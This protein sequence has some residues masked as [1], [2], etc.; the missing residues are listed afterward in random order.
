MQAHHVS[1]VGL[2]AV[3]AVVGGLRTQEQREDR[4]IGGVGQHRREARL[5][6]QGLRLRPSALDRALPPAEGDRE[7]LLLQRRRRIENVEHLA[8]RRPRARGRGPCA[9]DERES[10]GPARLGDGGA[11][12][13]HRTV[14]GC[15]ARSSGARP[16]TG[17][18]PVVTAPGAEVVAI[19]IVVVFVEVVVVLGIDVLVEVLIARFVFRIGLGAIGLSERGLCVRLAGLVEDLPVPHGAATPS[20]NEPSVLFRRP[21]HGPE[22]LAGG[23]A[24]AVVRARALEGQAR[25]LPAHL[26][27]IGLAPLDDG[28]DVRLGHGLQLDRAL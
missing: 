12:T 24:A 9:A 22:V 7:P 6:R 16:G 26:D 3:R 14:A 1:R 17:R 23:R 8:V 28:A 4:A 2:V 25:G 5:Q 21:Q 10:L 13:W 19:V 11:G 20:R 18:L 27:R 15:E